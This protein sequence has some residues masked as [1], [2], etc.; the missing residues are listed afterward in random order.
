MFQ[1]VDRASYYLVTYDK[2]NR[3]V[4]VEPYFKPLEAVTA[5]DKAEQ[6]GNIDGSETE[7]IVLVEAGKL[8]NVKYGFPNYFGDV[9]LFKGN[10]QK[11]VKGAQAVEYTLIPQ[12]AV[13]SRPGSHRSCLA[14]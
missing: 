11:I 6:P 10:L 7:D 5:Y 1:S 3:R 9:Q 4:K 13:P 8:E 14:T 2:V 12:A